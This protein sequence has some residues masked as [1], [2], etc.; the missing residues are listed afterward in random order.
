MEKQEG[1]TVEHRGLYSVSCNNPKW[2]R[3]GKRMYVYV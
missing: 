1:P 3:I 2:Q